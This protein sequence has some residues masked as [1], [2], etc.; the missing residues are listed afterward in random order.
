MRR[1]PLVVLAG[2]ACV[3]ASG[4]DAW[5]RLALWSGL[6]GAAPLMSDPAARGLALYRAGDYAAA[7]AALAGAGRGQTFNRALTLAA[8]GNYALS[9]AYL[10]AVLFADPGDAEAARLRGLIDAL[11]P[12]VVGDSVAPGR[13]A[14]VGGGAAAA[15]A[16]GALPSTPDPEWKKPIEARGFVATD[17]WLDTITDDPGEFLRLRLEKEHERRAGLGL[18]RPPEGDRW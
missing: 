5:G 18:I 4:P 7:D 8:T 1:A 13:L 9:V 14:A 3:L 10:D 17:A 12:K 11:V 2:L 16:G 6:P 15:G